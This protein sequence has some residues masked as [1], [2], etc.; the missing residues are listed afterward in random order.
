MPSFLCNIE[1]GKDMIVSKQSQIKKISLW[2]LILL[3]MGI[4]FFFSAQNSNDSSHLS[5]SF[6]ENV[7]LVFLPEQ[8]AADTDLLQQ[9]SFLIRK[10]AHMT[11]YAIL[12]ILLLMQIRLYGWLT[13]QAS[14]RKLSAW[15][16]TFLLQA[17]LTT[18]IVILYAA[19]DEFHQLF[20]SG[21]SGQA[22]DVLIDTCGGLFGILF[23]FLLFR[24][25]KN[26]R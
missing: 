1:K 25:R 20:V 21:R 9:L 6:L 24:I 5:S 18:G 11:E 17:L 10:C 15:T 12:A 7:I 23:Y 26:H 22:T 3:W 8:T 16:F 13:A 2:C 4:I 19:S 14:R